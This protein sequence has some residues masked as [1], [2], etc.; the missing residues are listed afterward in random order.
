[1]LFTN[2]LLGI[3]GAL[4]SLLGRAKYISQDSKEEKRDKYAVSQELFIPFL[5]YLRLG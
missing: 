5:E 2:P 4:K 3:L 1:M